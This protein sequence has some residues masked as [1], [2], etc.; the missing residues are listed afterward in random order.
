[1]CSILLIF[2]FS[3]DY[4]C[5]LVKNF[6]YFYKEINEVEV[7]VLLKYF[8]VQFYYIVVDNGSGMGFLEE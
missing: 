8:N 4:Y 7:K 1:M 2:F 6:D 5:F 3:L